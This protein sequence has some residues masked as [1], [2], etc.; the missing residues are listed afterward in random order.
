MESV[1][2]GQSVRFV[3]LTR[4]AGPWGA[5][6][7]F[8]WKCARCWALGISPWLSPSG[9]SPSS[10]AGSQSVGGSRSCAALRRG[11]WPER[12][13]GA[14]S[15]RRWTGAAGE[16]EEVEGRRLLWVRPLLAPLFFGV[17]WEEPVDG[18]IQN[19]V[20]PTAGTASA[21]GQKTLQ[22]LITFTFNLTPLNSTL[23][24]KTASV[25]KI[26]ILQMDSREVD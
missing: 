7:G 23:C 26:L 16:E 8:G 21:G 2:R 6:A 18:N 12:G 25:C 17:T 11:S 24:G 3:C 4:W 19:F 15:L 1:E 13:G 14:R 10:S 9:Q 20:P 22:L 5:A